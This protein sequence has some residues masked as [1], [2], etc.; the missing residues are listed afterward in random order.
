MEYYISKFCGYNK[1]YS[2]EVFS[3]F[4]R[5]DWIEGNV[6]ELRDAVKY[7]CIKSRD[8]KELTLLHVN[9]NY[10]SKDTDIGDVNIDMN[11]MKKTVM[12][13][14]Y[15]TYLSNLEKIVLSGL[16]SEEKSIRSLSK[17]IKLTDMTLGR[18]L[19]KYNLFIE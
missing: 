4:M 18:K 3:L 16:V 13:I 2:V 17:K 15:E 12:D 9:H 14:G 5:H 11:V 10:Y 19:K 6:R 1:P 8:E 7:M